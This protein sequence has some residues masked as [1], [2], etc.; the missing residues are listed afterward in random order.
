[1]TSLSSL[2]LLYQLSDQAGA[3]DLAC[4]L[5]SN[6]QDEDIREWMNG[7]SDDQGY[8]L[9]SDD[10]IIQ[11]VTQQDKTTKEDEEDDCEEIDIPS[12][13]EMKDMLDKCLVCYERQ[14]E[15]T[16]T[17]LLQLKLIRDLVAN[18]CYTNLKQLK[19]DSFLISQ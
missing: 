1:M 13:I 8:Q 10:D 16:S 4:Q 14:E 17:S 18:K 2:H 19:L 11:H 3:E 6:L 15:S 5:D 12:A 9:L 7:D